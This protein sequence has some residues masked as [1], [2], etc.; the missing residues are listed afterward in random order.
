[1][2]LVC[3]AVTQNPAC[4]ASGCALSFWQQNLNTIIMTISPILG[5][6][7]LWAQNLWKKISKK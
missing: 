1:M 7:Y 5:G 2:C 3:S 6:I 4:G